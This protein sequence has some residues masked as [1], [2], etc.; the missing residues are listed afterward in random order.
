M[1]HTYIYI[2][3]SL[4]IYIYILS[5]S[6]SLSLSLFIYIYI[7]F[8]LTVELY[9]TLWN[10][11]F[12]RSEFIPHQWNYIGPYT[13]AI[14]LYRTAIQ[15]EQKL[16]PMS[17]RTASTE[18]MAVEPFDDLAEHDA[19]KVHEGNALA[20]WRGF[21]SPSPVSTISY[22]SHQRL[23]TRLQTDCGGWPRSYR[24]QKAP[25]HSGTSLTFAK[26]AR[27]GEGEQDSSRCT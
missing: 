21:Q 16:L 9:W 11:G 8:S 20:R 17:Q 27:R 25:A 4:S 12:Y 23:R 26:T 22:G 13:I 6:H 24:Q 3:L 19:K 18:V 7:I 15:K 2:S 5:L 1:F 10:S 14:G